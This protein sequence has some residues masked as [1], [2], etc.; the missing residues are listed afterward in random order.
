MVA[1]FSGAALGI[2]GGLVVMPLL[3]LWLPPA[4]AVAYAAPMFLAA[5]AVNFARYR[6]RIAWPLLW[7]YIPGVAVGSV[8]GAH[9]LQVAPSSIIRLVMGGLALAFTILEGLRLVRRK[10]IQAGRRWVAWPLSVAG[11]L[12]ST[13]TNIGGTV[14]SAAMLTESLTQAWYVGTLNAVMLSMGVFKIGLFVLEG[15]IRPR[16]FVAALPAIPAVFVGSWLGQR[17][18]QRLSP[19]MFRWV[20]VSVIGASSLML[21]LG[22]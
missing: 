18:N 4:E 16:G 17:F 6:R 8:V 12:A 7:R 9:F 11:G 21:L 2:G 10:P 15:L 19:A 5:S 20:L 13:L 3:G 22:A 1:S 14:V